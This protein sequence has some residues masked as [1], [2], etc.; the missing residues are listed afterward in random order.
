MSTHAVSC[1]LGNVDAFVYQHIFNL[2]RHA[3]H[4]ALDRA[5]A[6]AVDQQRTEKTPRGIHLLFVGVAFQQG[7]HEGVCEAIVQRAEIGLGER[8]DKHRKA[9]LIVNK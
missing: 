7:I 4:R 8:R 9:G 2:E 5:V 1:D 6:M 3:I